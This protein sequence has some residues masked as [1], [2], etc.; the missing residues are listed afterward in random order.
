MNQLDCAYA[1]GLFDG[2]GC[3][4]LM[5]GPPTARYRIRLKIEVVQIEP[6]CLYWLALRFGGKVISRPDRQF[7]RRRMPYRWD[8][9]GKTAV[10]FLR[11][12]RPY[13][14]VKAAQADIA[15]EFVQ[16][17]Q[18]KGGVRIRIPA[19]NIERREQLR[20]QMK[21]LNRRGAA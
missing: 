15:F 6:T 8:L 18:S 5:P 4:L 1:A 20:L 14:I 7:D 13:L 9:C 10:A 12:I 17:L 2:E 19:E 16:L 3:V 11:L 21:L